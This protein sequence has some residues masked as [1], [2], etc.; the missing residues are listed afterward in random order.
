[1]ALVVSG[2]CTVTIGMTAGLQRAGLEPS[3]VWV[4]AHGDLQSATRPPT[5]R[6]WKRS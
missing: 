1:M 2:D 6:A 4:D 5:D 3:I